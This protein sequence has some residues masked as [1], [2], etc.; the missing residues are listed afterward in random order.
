MALVGAPPPPQLGPPTSA[1]PSPRPAGLPTAT[2]A[3]IAELNLD[4]TIAQGRGFLKQQPR[5]AD[6]ARGLIA[7]LLLRARTRNAFEDFDDALEVAEKMTHGNPASP[8]S[9]LGLASVQVALHQFDAAL[10]SIDRAARL[11]AQPADVSAQR[12]SIAIARG[13]SQSVLPALAQAARSR[14]DY[15]THSAHAIALQELGRIEEADAAYAAALAAYDDVSAHAIA[16][17]FFQRGVLW[18]EADPAKARQYYEYALTYLPDHITTNVHLAELEHAAGDTPKA[19]A[20]MQRIV[21]RSKDPEPM[22]LLAT[23]LIASG[24]AAEARPWIDRARAG[25]D[26]L[27]AKHRLAFVDHAAEFYGGVGDDGARALQLAEEN[28]KNRHT[29]RAYRIAAA[30]AEAANNHA[31]ACTLAREARALGHPLSLDTCAA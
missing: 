23:L 13:D 14:P 4:F 10:A 1:P 9:W 22:G 21:L 26:A 18:T 19:L 30:A 12:G 6:A 20:R 24:R 11:G 2:S 31:R 27:L 16:W 15:A 17:V 28:L 5:A 3:N 7:A 25:Y 29:R 8:D